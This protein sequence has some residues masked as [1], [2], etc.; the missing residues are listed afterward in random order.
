MLHKL[1]ADTKG[2]HDIV[3]TVFVQ[4]WSM[5]RASGPDKLR[6]VGEAEFVN[7]VAAIGA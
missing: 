3:A 7:G 2:G 5:Y 4:C 1:L 6:P